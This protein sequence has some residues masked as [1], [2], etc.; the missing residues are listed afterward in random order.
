M[1]VNT[2]AV[3]IRECRS[4]TARRQF[5]DVG[6]IHLDLEPAHAGRYAQLVR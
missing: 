3:Q 4:A 5:D 2:I 1:L 6:L